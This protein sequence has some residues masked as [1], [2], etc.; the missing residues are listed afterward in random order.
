MRPRNR[1]LLVPLITFLLT[2]SSFL[3]GASRAS[4][5][6]ASD[7]HVLLVIDTN[8]S[9]RGGN[10]SVLRGGMEANLKHLRDVINE[11]YGS[12]EEKFKGR[13][14]LNVLEGDEVTPDNIRKAY[15]DT[16]ATSTSSL[17]F[18]YCG[19]GTFD[20]DKGHYLATSGGDITRREIR[21]ILNG[22]GAR[23]IVMITDCCSSYATFEPPERRV[24]A[25]WKVFHNLFFENTGIVDI[26]AA[27]EGEF[28]WVNAEEGGFFTRALTKWLCEPSEN[29]REDEQEGFVSWDAFFAKVKET[30]MDTFD[31]AK[32]GAADGDPIKKSEAQTPYTWSL[33]TWPEQRTRKLVVKNETNVRLCIWV[34]Y[35]DRDFETNKW[36]WYPQ[37]GEKS[38][39]YELDPG[40][41]IRLLDENGYWI[42]A[43]AFVIW[44]SAAN[45]P[46][47]KWG[48][49]NQVIKVVE[50]SYKGQMGSWTQ[51]FTP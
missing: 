7:L 40:K 38:L 48:D 28:G 39:Y 9:K 49:K 6:V 25:K 1:L 12:E 3:A 20:K 43:N 47:L 27:T 10:D 45:N 26:T 16:S 22:T 14:F 44:A 42:E 51:R 17:F 24:P 33:G 11:V 50:E 32:E 2:T 31:R 8:A 19:H 15:R 34:K 4:A 5:E 23:S 18:Y 21:S 30:T 29:I 35:Y 36:G 46:N 37:G 41:A 13:F